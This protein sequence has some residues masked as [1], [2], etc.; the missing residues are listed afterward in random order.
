MRYTFAILAVLLAVVLTGCKQVEPKFKPSD[1][2]WGFTA[3]RLLD[4]TPK[5]KGSFRQV[6]SGRWF[7][8]VFDFEVAVDDAPALFARWQTE[9]ESEL[10]SSGTEFTPNRAQLPNLELIYWP[11]EKLTGTLHLFLTPLPHG[12]ARVTG[13]VYEY[14]KDG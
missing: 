13:L 14:G 7:S 2:G 4:E 1:F 8:R 9:I 11:S 6:L 10:R 12:R 5:T 3:D